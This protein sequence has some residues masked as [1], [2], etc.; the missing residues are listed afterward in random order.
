MGDPKATREQAAVAM[1]PVNALPVPWVED[2]DIS[3]AALFLASRKPATLRVARVETQRWM[4]SVG[5]AHLLAGGA[6]GPDRTHG[7]RA[8]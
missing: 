7:C 5:G 6:V 3:N 8:G 1:Q 2:R 4:S